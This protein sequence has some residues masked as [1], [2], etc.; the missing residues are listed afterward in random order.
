MLKLSECNSNNLCIDCDNWECSRCGDIA[1]DCPKYHCDNDT[2]DC[3]NCAF[4]K[5][6][7]QDMRKYYEMER[8]KNNGS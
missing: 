6:Y 3:N 4:I 2:H 7:Q 8:S 5:Q 1:A